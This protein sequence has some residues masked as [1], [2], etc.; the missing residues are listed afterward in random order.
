MYIVAHV[1]FSA[2]AIERLT[3]AF[4]ELADGSAVAFEPI[5]INNNLN[6]SSTKQIS[7]L[8]IKKKKK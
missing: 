7:K 4:E 3:T 2:H 5:R 6:S 1:I 8:Y